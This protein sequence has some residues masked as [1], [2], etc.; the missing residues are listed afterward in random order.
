MCPR[1]RLDTPIPAPHPESRERTPFQGPA[2]VVPAAARLGEVGCPSPS[3]R[4]FFRMRGTI[5]IESDL[6]I[7]QVT[8]VTFKEG[9]GQPKVKQGRAKPGLRPRRPVPRSSLNNAAP[10]R[11]PGLSHLLPPL[12]QPKGGDPEARGPHPCPVG[13]RRLSP[14]SGKQ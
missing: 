11:Y 9:R 8:K 14:P 4:T 5:G 10:L 3:S 2:G 7:V 12:L 13:P 1:V 6:I